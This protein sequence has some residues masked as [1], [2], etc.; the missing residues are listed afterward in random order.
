MTTQ[1]GQPTSQ[2]EE[3]LKT[4]LGLLQRQ[5]QS[6]RHDVLKNPQTARLVQ[7]LTN[8]LASQQRKY[9][10]NT[11]MLLRE[12]TRLLQTQTQ[13]TQ[14]FTPP[15]SLYTVRPTVTTYPSIYQ[16][17]VLPTVPSVHHPI[18][19]PQPF[20]QPLTQPYTQHVIGVNGM[21]SGQTVDSKT[22]ISTLQNLG[23][24]G[25][26]TQQQTAPKIPPEIYFLY[27]SFSCQC[28]NCARRFHSRDE[29]AKH[30][31]MHYKIS[32]RKSKNK[33]LSR[34]WFQT[35]EVI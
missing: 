29:L 2:T 25:G 13:Q 31:D 34:K 5:L 7:Q 26:P 23:Y 21:S 11:E 12:V 17:S 30:M 14:Q 10:Q 18:I 6:G 8:V 32:S 28:S 22:L 35:M 16:P 24:L 33:V 1:Y 4:L 27:N 3:L 20:T 9:S 15:Q 19:Q